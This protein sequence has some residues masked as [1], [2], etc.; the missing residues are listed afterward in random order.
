MNES[1]QK[2]LDRLDAAID[3]SA[4]KRKRRL[5]CSTSP[6]VFGLAWVLGYALL[7]W[8]VPKLWENILPGG[9]A[10]ASFMQGAP[11]VVWRTGWYCHDHG[12]RVLGAGLVLFLVASAAT[13][14]LATRFFVWLLALGMIAID[15]AI[16]LVALKT[17]MDAQGLTQLLG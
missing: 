9:F 3:L 2:A 6:L 16:L 15:A 12:A 14:H 4:K 1:T 10:R 17:G 11:W 8:L 5:G 13:R 7:A